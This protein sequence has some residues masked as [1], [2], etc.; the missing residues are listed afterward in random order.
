[1]KL[2][3]VLVLVALPL[4]AGTLT[5]S[6]TPTAPE[7]PS[8]SVTTRNEV[9][10]SLSEATRRAL[11]RNHDIALERESFKIA[12]L[13]L[14]RAAGAY[15][16]SFH[17]EARY[18]DHTDPVNSVLSGALPGQDAP[19]Q[20]GVFGSASLTQLLPTGGSVALSTSIARERTDSLFA[21]LAPSYT[22]LLGIDLR[23]P[24]LQNRTTDPARHAIRIARIDR[25]RSEWSLRR[26]V[27][28]TLTAVEKAYWT[29]VAAQ[30]DVAVRRSSVSLAQEQRSDAQ[31]RIEAGTLPESDLAQPTAEIE[32]RRGELFG[33]EEGAQRAENQLKELM[34]GDTE[35]PLWNATLLPTDAPETSPIPL[36]LQKAFQEARA[37]RPEL[38]E[39]RTRFER[40]LL[41]SETAKE[42]V[43]PQLD[44][45][46]SYSRRGLAGDL[47]PNAISFTGAPV[48]APEPLDGGLGRS[49]GTITENRF[50][51]ASIGLALT[52]P[53]S[54][55]AARADYAIA[56]SAERQ[57][58]IGIEQLRQ[59]IA[60]EV[61]NAALALKTAAQRI[62]AAHSG[63]LAAETQ[64]GAEKER[65]GVGLTTNF[66]VLTRQNELAAAQVTE[67]AA[68]TDYRKAMTDFARAVGTLLDD[69]DIQVQDQIQDQSPRTRG[70]GAAR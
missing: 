23:Q 21:V 14:D 40:Q 7:E 28:E 45:V 59:R 10:L 58:V 62:E 4:T 41:E 8:A 33:A 19:R 55:R 15:D 5:G 64:L 37:R 12:A 42:R 70:N 29:L 57:A 32:R 22:T 52:V 47:N 34:L 30:R 43:L 27:T 36:D 50:P 61:R 66:F 11:A 38:A 53:L 60:V 51:D 35:D 31:S 26:T 65:F 67:T 1:M 54:N 49:F 39:A 18:R 69:R 9:P 24:L 44:V 3:R 13:S 16:P 20:K 2:I 68:L 63:R 48:T 25:D 56:R 6:S 17:L 46:A